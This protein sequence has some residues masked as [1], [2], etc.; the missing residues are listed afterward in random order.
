MDLVRLMEAYLI[1]HGVATVGAMVVFL[2]RNE[3]RITKIE[4]TLS[5]LECHRSGKCNIDGDCE[6]IEK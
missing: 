1:L 5:L 3:H 2:M 6:G 4:T